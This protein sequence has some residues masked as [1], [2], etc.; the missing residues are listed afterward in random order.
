M[1][2]I[3]YKFKKISTNLI[4][5]LTNKE[6]KSILGRERL[7]FNRQQ[8]IEYIQIIFEHTVKQST[9][10]KLH[11][12]S[13]SK[14]NYSCFMNNISLFAKLFHYLFNN[15]NKILG[16]FPSKLLNIVDTTLIEE[17]K[18]TFIT[19]N[20]WISGR[21]TTRINKIN[22]QKIFTCGS[23][24]LL[25]INR[26][27]KIYYAKI[28]DIKFSD[29]NILKDFSCYLSQLKG[30]LLADRGFNNKAVRERIS[31]IGNKNL[32]VNIFNTNQTKCRL[33]S[34]PHY[35]EKI[36]LIKKEQKLYKRRWKI[37]TVFQKLKQNYSN[38]KLNLKGKYTKLLKKAK[39]YTAL[40]I[41]NLS[42]Q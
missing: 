11:Q 39:F 9:F 20:D 30:I 42:T 1:K 6:I 4:Y 13:L 35:K 2:I 37:E 34:P 17:K 41:Y 32:I 5:S 16:I 7:K 10:K 21:V 27:K 19:Q 8:I 12:Q 24:G 33:I 23:K 25:F 3:P 40:I 31:N 18:N 26:F 36:K 29:Q 14:I 15:I 38:N 28:L 22:Q